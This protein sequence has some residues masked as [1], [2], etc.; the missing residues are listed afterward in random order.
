MNYATL[1]IRFV[2]DLSWY[3]SNFKNYNQKLKSNS[4]EK[5]IIPILQKS[6]LINFDL[7]GTFH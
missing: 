3:L 2:R 5:K 7:N 1:V 6:Q 4:E